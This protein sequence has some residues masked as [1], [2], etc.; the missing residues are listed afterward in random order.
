MV[1]LA[2]SILSPKHMDGTAFPDKEGCSA[3]FRAGEA[4]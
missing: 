1:E 4:Y 2:G 3:T